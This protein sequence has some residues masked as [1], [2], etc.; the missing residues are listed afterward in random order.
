MVEGGVVILT[1]PWGLFV[2]ELLLAFPKLCV[3]VCVFLLPFA[4]SPLIYHPRLL[5]LIASP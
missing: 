3:C 1:I 4:L 2:P 5:F